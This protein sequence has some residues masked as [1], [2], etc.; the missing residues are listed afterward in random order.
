MS[1]VTRVRAK[2]RCNSIEDFGTNKCIKLTAIYGKEGE[3]ADY[4]KYTPFGE[5]KIN[6][7][8]ET[9]ASTFFVP[10]RNYYLDFTDAPHND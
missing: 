3:N 5:L 1:E 6:I 9:R 7:D 4:S 8:N 2:F 10:G